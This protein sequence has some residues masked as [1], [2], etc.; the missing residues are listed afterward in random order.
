M[1]T[2]QLAREVK[3]LRFRTDRRVD[4][5]FAGNYR[6]AFKGQG[7][8][9]ADVREYEPG[10]DVR[11][12]DWN[13]TARAGKPF[14]KR[15]V[16]ERQLTVMLL[17]DVS[18]SERFASGDRSKRRLG[19]EVASALALA[20]SRSRD[21]VGLMLFAESPELFLAP[22]TGRPH[23]L[24]MM[25][26][27]IAFEPRAGGTDLVGALDR[28]GSMLRRRA[29][30]FVVSDF[31][32][33]AEGPDGYG[34]ALR[35]LNAR[36]DVIAIR[37]RDPR[38]EDIPAVGLIRLRDPETGA[39]RLVDL[40]RRSVRRHRREYAQRL[41]QS[42]QALARAGVDLAECRTDRPFLRE[43]IGVFERRSR[44]GKVA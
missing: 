33:A 3:R 11:S 15:F 35:R 24:H 17:V 42:N 38:E 14:I 7:L 27:L 31:L 12:I 29:I 44:V 8:E 9:F 13:V 1:L 28:C 19:T 41:A 25:R 34:P 26:E 43:L 32:S 21:R 4:D 20:A 23:L 22:R 2:D 16:E 30:V 40:T 18:A 5:L 37:L 39:S 36:H 6:S 10:D